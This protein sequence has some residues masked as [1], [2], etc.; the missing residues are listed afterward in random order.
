[1]GK[2]WNER[3]LQ[4]LGILADHGPMEISEVAEH[5][6]MSEKAAGTVLAR[7]AKWW[8]VRRTKDKWAKPQEYELTENGRERL[9]WLREQRE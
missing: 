3:K 8:L 1:M 5:A 4:I 9:V 6:D 2:G 7:Y